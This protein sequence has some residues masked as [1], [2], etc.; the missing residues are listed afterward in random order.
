[1]ALMELVLSQT[2]ANQQ[3]VN[4][5]NFQSTGTPAAV[6]LSYALVHAFGAILTDGIPPLSYPTGTLMHWIRSMQNTG[7]S[8]DSI[9]ARDLYS[10]TDFYETPFQGGTNGTYSGEG[11]SPAM[12]FGFR[13]T[14]TRLDIRRA[15]KRFVGVSENHV[16]SFGSIDTSATDIA[17][18]VELMG[19]PLEYDD[20]GNTITFSPIVLGKERYQTS[21][22]GVTPVKWAY[23]KYETE[24]EQLEHIAVGV[25]WEA[26]DN[27]RSQRSR[28]YGVGQ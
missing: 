21:A 4:R 22:P 12:A 8:F 2:Y 1:M 26:Y 24:A 20:E 27:V 11:M 16:G 18:I 15:T 13:S 3:C 9:A 6:S 23:R 7:V 17:T 28:Q 25:A 19:S 10:V 14:R 5:W